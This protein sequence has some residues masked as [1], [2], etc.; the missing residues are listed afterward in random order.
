MLSAGFD[1]HRDDPVGGLGLASDDF[2]AL[3]KTVL[4][5]AQTHASGRLI[6]LL[7]GGYNPQALAE[8]VEIHI[9]ELLAGAG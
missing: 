6:S 4:E 2:R 1:S 8:C 9:A 7:E 3:T 5:I